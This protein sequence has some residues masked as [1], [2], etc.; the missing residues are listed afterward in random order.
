MT[1]AQHRIMRT[2]SV[3]LLMFGGGWPGKLECVMRLEKA[4]MSLYSLHVS[5][6]SFDC[7]RVERQFW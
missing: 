4:I 5:Y 2:E 7:G 3:L 6:G 1:R